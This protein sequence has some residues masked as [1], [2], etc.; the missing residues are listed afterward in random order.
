LAC[1]YTPR[2]ALE[3]A[4]TGYGRLNK[5]I[6]L[7]GFCDFSL[8]DISRTELDSKFHLPRFNMP[9]EL[10]LAFG[11]KHFR[12][13]TKRMNALVLDRELHRYEKFLSDLKGWDPVSHGGDPLESITQVR[14]WLSSHE[15]IPLNGPNHIKN[16]FQRF[17][18]DLP[19]IREAAG[20][21]PEKI[22][23]NDLVFSIRSW[24]EVNIKTA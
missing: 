1:G 14:N 11:R 24:L 22:E 4:D 19:R 12:H 15:P 3:F 2:C 13:G 9:F 21:E 20:W 16:W 7:T 6:D 8:H 18:T 10:G 5:I 23:F 17:Q